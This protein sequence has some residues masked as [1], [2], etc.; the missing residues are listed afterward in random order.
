MIT[1]SYHVPLQSKG[2]RKANLILNLFYHERRLCQ[3][4]KFKFFNLFSRRG[5]ITYL[6]ISIVAAP[7]NE[8]TRSMISKLGNLE[9]HGDLDKN[10]SVS[11]TTNP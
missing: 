8:I 10:S 1:Y 2:A 3:E 11:D 9:K 6:Y 5:L 4:E 7:Y